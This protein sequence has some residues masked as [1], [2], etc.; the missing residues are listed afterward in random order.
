[1]LGYWGRKRMTKSGLGSKGGLR[2]ELQA[3]VATALHAAQGSPLQPVQPPCR[4]RA[5]RFEEENRPLKKSL[6]AAA[7]HHA[8]AGAVVQVDVGHLNAGGQGG[9]VHGEV[10][11]LGRHLWVEDKAAGGVASAGAWPSRAAC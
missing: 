5:W 9:G 4:R 6:A 10:V 8:G 2:G 1:M 11:V 3:T 7:T